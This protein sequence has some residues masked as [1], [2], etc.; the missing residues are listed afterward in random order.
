M[1]PSEVLRE[2]GGVADTAVL[3]ARC[4]RKAIKRALESGDIIRLRRGVYGVPGI[5]EAQLRSIELSATIVGPSAAL[6]WE[7]KLKHLPERP[8]LALF[9]GRALTR[10]QRAQIVPHW[11]SSR[12]DVLINAQGACVQT[13]LATAVHCLRT[14][15]FDEALA[16]ADSALRSGL[17][18]R[19]DLLIAIASAPRIGRA[20]AEAVAR[21]ADRRSANPFESVLRAIC[22]DVRGLDVE[23]QVQIG[24]YRVDLAD[25]HRRMVIEAESR[26]W[27]AGP[28]EHNADIRRYTTL[29]REGWLVI[30]FSYDD[31]M[32]DPGYVL[33]VLRDVLRLAPVRAA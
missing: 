21:A 7:W 31:V 18:T 32:N 9:K 29:V 20:R 3:R 30:R 5:A 14:M 10:R 6:I 13:P 19:D 12:G 11:W 22:R 25:R 1:R 8:H 27:H 23:P 24:P 4:G 2:S 26:E 28:A 33:E 16:V 15:P 17:V